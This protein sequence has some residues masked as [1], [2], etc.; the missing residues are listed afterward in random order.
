MN[1]ANIDEFKSYKSYDEVE[2]EIVNEYIEEAIKTTNAMSQNLVEENHSTKAI[3]ETMKYIRTV[4][5]MKKKN[6]CDDDC[7][8]CLRYDQL[9]YYV[10]DFVKEFMKHDI[11]KFREIGLL[12]VNLEEEKPKNLSKKQ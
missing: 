6:D 8:C 2:T 9:K 5:L 10:I 12:L 11:K 3:N 4:T 7:R 1:S